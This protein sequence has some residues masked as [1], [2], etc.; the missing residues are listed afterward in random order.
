[1][2][3]TNRGLAAGLAIA[4]L[5]LAGCESVS[6][7]YVRDHEPYHIEDGRIV[8]EQ[9]AAERLGIDTV[10]VRQ[11]AGNAAGGLVIPYAALHYDPNGK[12]FAYTEEDTLTY[13]REQIQ[14]RRIQ[15]GRVILSDG[16]PAGTEV[17]TVGVPELFGIEEGVGH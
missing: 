10:P 9:K 3:Y 5:A 14:V 7:D 16:P 2:R 13:V 11:A 4:A 12:T 17:V 8:L 1:M 6:T 15:N